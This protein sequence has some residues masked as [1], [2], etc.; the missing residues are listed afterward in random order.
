MF[1]KILINT[2]KFKEIQHS[3]I[4]NQDSNNPKRSC[5]LKV[6]KSLR[7]PFILTVKRNLRHSMLIV[8]VYA[9]SVFELVIFLVF[10]MF[11]LFFTFL[12]F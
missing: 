1:I 7:L 6:I 9:N 10:Y 8:V 3:W 11:R 2:G 12:H 5:L 4:L